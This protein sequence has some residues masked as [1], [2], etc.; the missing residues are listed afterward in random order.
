MFSR[1][2]VSDSLRPHGL[3]PTRLLGPWDFPGENTGVGCHFLLQGICPTQGLS[4]HLLCLLHCRRCFT[5]WAT[6]DSMYTLTPPVLHVETAPKGRGPLSQHQSYCRTRV[7][8]GA[9]ANSQPGAP[10]WVSV[11]QK[12]AVGRGQ[13]PSL[14]RKCPGRVSESYFCPTQELPLVFYLSCHLPSSLSVLL[15]LLYKKIMQKH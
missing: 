9:P 2:V 6:E 4:P 11:G 7:Q 1:S 10:Q 15:N 5:R 3:Q 14:F 13:S 8:K 12:P